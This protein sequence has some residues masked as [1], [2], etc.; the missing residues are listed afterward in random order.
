MQFSKKRHGKAMRNDEIAQDD[1]A[2]FSVP[3]ILFDVLD[4]VAKS[5][6]KARE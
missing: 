5:E 1:N 6:V 3:G 2:V 4:R